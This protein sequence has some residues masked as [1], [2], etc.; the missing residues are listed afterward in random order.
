MNPVVLRLTGLAIACGLLIG[1]ANALTHDTIETN[2]KAWASRQLLAVAGDDAYRIEELKPGLYALTGDA[3][4]GFVFEV[5]T[6]EAYNG[7][8]AL[9]LAVDENGEILGVRVKD[10]RETPGLGD[11]IELA[12]SDWILS[13]DGYSLAVSSGAWEVRRD[14]GD[15]DQFTGA[16]I[17]PRAVVH[18]VRDGLIEFRENREAWLGEL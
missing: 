8:I 13:F 2:R 14:G 18:A 7:R 1:V 9:W 4:R 6:N 17:T 5:I 10:H 15:F 11:K 3:G 16:T 12:V